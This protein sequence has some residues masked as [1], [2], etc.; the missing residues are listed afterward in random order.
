MKK[1]TFLA[2]FLMISVI[3]F[4]QTELIQD[5]DFSDG[6]AT[7][8]ECSSFAGPLTGTESWWR[9][10]LVNVIGS[11]LEYPTDKGANVRQRISLEADTYYE[12]SFDIRS[13]VD[14]VA[15]GRGFIASFRGESNLEAS[16]ETCFKIGSPENL[17]LNFNV[18]SADF[19]T[20]A[21]THKFG[22][23]SSEAQ[24]VVINLIRPKETATKTAQIVY[25]SNV[26]MI[27]KN[28]LS[29]Q[30]LVEFNFSL[31]PNPTK[32]ML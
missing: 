31:S 15:G 25:L 3:S 30:D 6:I 20:T 12:V 5:Q 21:E 2:V 27:K 1:I 28:T 4:G 9:C 18:P 17:M 23:Y 10:G 26:S 14:G 24:N 29:I 32:N 7:V 8:S 22:F 11:E 16:L 13:D 19:T